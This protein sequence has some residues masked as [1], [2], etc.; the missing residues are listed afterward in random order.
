MKIINRS[1]IGSMLLGLILSMNGSC[2]KDKGADPIPVTY[3]TV[4]DIEGN[5]YKTIQI[6]IPSGISKGPEG[7]ETKTQTWMVENLKT[8]KYSNGDVI[9][10]TAPATLDI[11]D[12]VGARYQWPYEGDEGNVATYGRLYTWYAATD[13]RNICPSGWHVPTNDEWTAL[14][15]FLGGSDV[16]GG[17]LKETGTTHWEAPNTGASN[18]IGF[19]ALPAGARWAENSLFDYIN[20]ASYWWTSTEYPDY[21]NGYREWAAFYTSQGLW[22]A[23]SPPNSGYSVRCLKD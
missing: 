14:V 18:S 21:F 11:S 6:E 2:T 19:T 9:Q 22:N 13:S 23:D 4:T 7:S 20:T 15:N 3:G 5:V 16:A 12:E 10:T 1:F 8:K 17:K